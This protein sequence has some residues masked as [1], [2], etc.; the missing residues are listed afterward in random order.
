MSRNYKD[1]KIYC[2]RNTITDD[3][4]IGSSC[5]KYLSKR[6]VKHKSKAQTND[7]D[8]N[9]LL[10]QKM[11]ELGVGNFYIELIE[12]YPCESNDELRAREGHY[13]RKMA[14]L[15]KRVE[16]RTD[17]EWREDNKEYIQDWRKQY[18]QENKTEIDEKAKKYAEE[19]PDKVKQ[20]KKDYYERN[21]EQIKEYGKEYR[22]ENEELVKERKKDYYERNKEYVKA[23]TKAYREENIEADK[24]IKKDYY[25]R[26]KEHLK[27]KSSERAKEKIICECGEFICKG[28]ISRHIKRKRHQAYLNQQQE[29]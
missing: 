17:K 25:E 20:Q 6:W 28:S 10:Y 27:Q 26:N 13:I 12:N 9:M 19:N 18:Y 11:R 3:I 23:K 29:K 4:Y 2:V 15:N 21:K 1:G 14:T 5:E 24:Q 16:T 8:S 22:K 7:K